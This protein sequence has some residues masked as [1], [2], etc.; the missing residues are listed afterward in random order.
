[1]LAPEPAYT[2]DRTETLA[3]M[4]QYVGCYPDAVYLESDELAHHLGRPVGDV[5]AALDWLLRDG[6]EVAP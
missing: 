2:S 6:L 4:R 5:E 1:M 3:V